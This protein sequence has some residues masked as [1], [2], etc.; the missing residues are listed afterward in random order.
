MR[1]DEALRRRV[2]GEGMRARQQ[3]VRHD[4]PGV[5]IRAVVH[6]LADGLLRRHVGGGTERASRL[7]QRGRGRAIRGPGGGERLGDAE[8]GD[9][10]GP[11]REEHVLGLDV[12]M[13]DALVVGVV[14]R[15]GHVPQ[16]G[17]PFGQ[18]ERLGAGHP[19]AERLAPHVRHGV[20]G[21]AVGGPGV[22]DRDDVGVLQPG[23]EPDL[24]GEAL[25]AQ[26]L[27]ELGGDD[28][29]HD[30]PIERRLRGDPDAR[31]PTT[32]ELPLDPVVAGQRVDET[33]FGLAHGRSLVGGGRRWG[34]GWAG[35]GGDGVGGN[36]RRAGRSG[37]AA[38]RTLRGRSGFRP[39]RRAWT[40][41]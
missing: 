14:E 16:Q 33:I 29:D 25:G 26:A 5:E 18:R 40:L 7:R 27:R 32:A 20:V 4:A 9:H 35:G 22:E 24:A 31:H 2:P 11:V 1:G 36:L 34:D 23:R 13:D 12:A 6:R 30:L 41:T 15:T 8:V 37:Q 10:R 21:E 38:P 28:L 3:L 17:H 19:G 39:G